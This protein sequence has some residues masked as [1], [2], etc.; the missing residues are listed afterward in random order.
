[1]IY[2][3]NYKTYP[4]CNCWWKAPSPWQG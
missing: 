4:S 1:M 2:L 3:C